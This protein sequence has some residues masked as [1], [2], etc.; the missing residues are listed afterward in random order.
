VSTVV[1]V[2]NQKGG[3]GKTTTAVNLS[4][5]LALAV[6]VLLVDV[7]P[8]ANATSSLGLDPR[9]VKPG[10][11]EVLLGEASMDDAI[12]PSGRDG[13]DVAPTS[14]GLAG[15]QVELL[16]LPDSARRL[17]T[18]LEPVRGRYDVTLIDCPPSLGMLTLN[19]LAAADALL[20]PVQCEYL[21]L[22][23]LGQV[24]ETLDLV[25][26]DVNPRL[27]LQAVVLTM[28]DARTNL[29]NQVAGDVRAHFPAETCETVIPRS[30]RLSE[31]PSFGKPV[32]EYD[33][34]SRGAAAY[35]ELAQELLR[36]GLLG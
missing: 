13:L 14:R 20:V 5:Y 7:D 18:V 10:M 33:P 4:A 15:A 6:R 16:D 17:K 29:S 21:A 25:R 30:I 2:A 1:A 35:A 26:A 31:A 36:R 3:V 9:T 8:Q 23:G 28:H 27:E 12:V 24:M 34:S 11:Y 22:E 32:L 19:A